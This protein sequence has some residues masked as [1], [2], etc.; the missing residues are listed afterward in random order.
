MD[1]VIANIV[2]FSATNSLI[3]LL[4]APENINKVLVYRKEKFQMITNTL[5][6]SK[7]RVELL[8]YPWEWST[9][10]FTRR[11]REKTEKYFTIT[12]ADLKRMFVGKRFWSNEKL[13]TKMNGLL[14][15]YGNVKIIVQFSQKVI[16]SLAI[17]RTF[18]PMSYI[19]FWIFCDVC[20]HVPNLCSY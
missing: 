4:M 5:K 7:E 13:N 9:G 16:F 3:V 8:L 6:I 18:Q 11:N 10:E 17:L 14:K 2:E 19:Q 12:F 15:E 1:C 20:I